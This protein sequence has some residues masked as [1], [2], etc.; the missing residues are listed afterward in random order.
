MADEIFAINAGGHVSTNTRS[1]IEYATA[2]ENGACMN[3]FR[4]YLSEHYPEGEAFCVTTMLLFASL[5]FL[6]PPRTDTCFSVLHTHQ[7]RIP[8]SR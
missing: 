3:I 6:K 2:T 1:E 8:V 4:K 7:R 5:K